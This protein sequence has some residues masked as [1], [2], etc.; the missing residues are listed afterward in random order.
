M[1]VLVSHVKQ[2]NQVTGITKIM[3]IGEF[4]EGMAGDPEIVRSQIE[5]WGSM[6]DGDNVYHVIDGPKSVSEVMGRS[7]IF[8]FRDG[9]EQMVRV[10]A[11][12]FMGILGGIDNEGHYVYFELAEVESYRKPGTGGELY[13]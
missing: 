2:I 9:S 5:R 11:V 8:T 4:V 3:K 1:N 10:M 12:G 13:A 6:M 7:Y